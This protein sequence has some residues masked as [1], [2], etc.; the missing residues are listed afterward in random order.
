M[1]LPWL[2]ACAPRLPSAAIADVALVGV[3]WEEAEAE[4][5]V[6]VDNPLWVEVPTTAVRWTIELDGHTV[7]SGS[8]TDLP[9]L[10]ADA[11]TVLRVPVVMRYAEVGAAVQT[12][13]EEVPY[14]FAAELDLETRAGRVTLPIE[15]SGTVPRPTPP[16]LDLIDV[17]FGRDGTVLLVD[18]ALA[19]GLP[20]GT[21]VETFDWSVAVDA[22][23]LGSG[24][25]EVDPGRNLVLPM[26][27]DVSAAAAASIATLLGQTST[28]H[29]DLGG[30]LGTP[31]GT[32]PIRWSRDVAIER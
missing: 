22:R 8:A 30:E 24:R 17:G 18:L 4:V 32:V 5:R 10:A 11:V 2:L 31:L 14:R 26:R 25:A 9:V 21:S 20:A 15:H 1:L 16:S 6:A 3:G 29:L 19:L 13:A 27:F 23:E 28:L 7:A 12:E